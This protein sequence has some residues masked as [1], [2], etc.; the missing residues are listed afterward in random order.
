MS[1]IKFAEV[2]KL[3][4]VLGNT[5]GCVPHSH[6]FHF[7]S[8]AVPSTTDCGPT[9]PKARSLFWCVLP[10][11]THRSTGADG[12]S[13]KDMVQSDILFTELQRIWTVFCNSLLVEFELPSVFHGCGSP[14]YQ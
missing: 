13:F 6:S 7:S 8:H 3:V 9:Q 14:R 4:E 2:S 11:C 1:V 12:G 10:G 5:P